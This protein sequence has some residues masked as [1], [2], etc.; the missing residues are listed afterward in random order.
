MGSPLLEEVFKVNGVPTHTFVEPNKYAELLSNLRTP[1]RGLIVEGPSG[2]GKTSAVETALKRLAV[3]DSITR[4]SARKPEH[5]EYIES[6][7]RIGAAG[8]VLVDDFHK[9]SAAT[10]S[11]LADYMKTLADTED[12]TTKIVIL[13]I[14]QAGESLIQLA[15]DLVNRLD[16]IRFENEPDEKVLELVRKGEDALNINITVK[17]EIM[18]SAQGSFFLAQMLCKEVCLASN[19]LERQDS[20]RETNVSFEAVR[21]SVWERLGQVFRKRCERFCRGTKL[22]K[23]G[24]APYLNILQ[25]LASSKSWTIDLNDTIRQH[26]NLRSSV[27][28]VVDKGFLQQLIDAD[29]DIKLVLH[30]DSDSTQLTAEDPQFF[31]Y[32]RNI[33]WRRFARDIGFISVDFER[34]YDF[35]LSFAGSDRKIAEAI[36]GELTEAE[37]EVFYDKNEQHRIL[38]TDVEEYLRPIYQTEAQFVVVLLGPDYPNRIWTKIESDAFK[39]RFQDGNVIPIWFKNALPGMF[40][41]TR[42]IGGIVFDPDKECGP[43]V[44]EICRM[45]LQKLFEARN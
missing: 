42:R 17:D 40:D 41:E 16:I 11:Q 32:L 10:R 1:G 13:G 30:F 8:T 33:P 43:Q 44:T 7:P 35:A 3:S 26:P 21:S 15:P 28:Q 39:E 36:F 31:F 23:E 25:W 5:I 9:L 2:I 37:V 6:L 12:R 38:A 29:P 22:R 27:S 19:V 18:A 24:R 4:L 14:N 45:L 34:R 20:I